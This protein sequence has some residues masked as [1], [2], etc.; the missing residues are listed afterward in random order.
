[1]WKDVKNYEGLYLVSNLGR[2]KS[3]RKN[4]ILSP[5]IN[6]RGRYQ[7]RFKVN[8]KITRPFVHRLVAEAFIPNPHNYPEINHKDENKLN[9]EISNL[10]WCTTKYNANYG[11][12]NKR[13][14]ETNRKK[15]NI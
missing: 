7:I 9:N 14:S 1:M 4:K 2:I 12:R 6:T 8:G 3:V 13:I 5:F 15:W 10:E 11:T